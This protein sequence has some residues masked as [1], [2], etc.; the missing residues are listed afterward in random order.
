MPDFR[1]DFDQADEEVDP[2]HRLLGDVTERRD[3]DEL[4]KVGRAKRDH[5]V[6]LHQQ[7][8]HDRQRNRQAEV[9]GRAANERRDVEDERI[10]PRSNCSALSAT[11]APG[12]CEPR[13]RKVTLLLQAGELRFQFGQSHRGDYRR[14]FCFTLGGSGFAPSVA[15]SLDS[16]SVAP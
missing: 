8:R 5:A 3:V 16:P 9:G 1:D 14:L 4:L 13:Q 15:A 2:A 6:H 11:V 10:A 12:Y 7:N